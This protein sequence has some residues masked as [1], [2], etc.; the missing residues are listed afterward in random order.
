[1]KNYFPVNDLAPR[2]EDGLT[3][4]VKK[5]NGPKSDGFAVVDNGKVFVIDIGRGGDAQLIRFLADLRDQWLGETRLADGESAKLELTLIISHAHPDHM[6]ALPLLL[7]D[8]RFCVTDIY[9][10]ERS[11]LSTD[12]PEELPHLTWFES[13][14]ESIC[15]ELSKRGHTAKGITRIPFGRVCSITVGS[16][17]SVL[18]IYSSP[19]DWSQDRPCDKEGLCFIR[20]NNPSCYKDKPQ[21]GYANGILNGNSLWVKVIKGK[22]SALITGDQRDCDEM[23]GAMIRYYGEDEFDCDVLKIPHHGESN[24]SPYLM[25]VA[26]PQFTVFTTSYEKATR[27]TVKLCEEMGCINYYTRRGDLFFFITKKEIKAFGIDPQ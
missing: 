3:L 5:V 15:E 12:L 18:K 24:Y 26:K 22:H 27:D 2:E 16:A 7:N 11:C 21:V 20:A 17:D 14:L 13:R 4:F 9:A 10:P 25:S 8:E 23:L 1:M 19:F 6:A